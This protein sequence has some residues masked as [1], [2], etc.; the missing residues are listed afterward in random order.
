MNFIDNNFPGLMGYGLIGETGNSGL[1]G[2]SVYI[3]HLYGYKDK[4]KIKILLSKNLSINNLNENIFY[5]VDDIFIDN[6]GEVYK[7][8]KL[9][10]NPDDCEYIKLSD[11]YTESIFLNSN[12][13]NSFGYKRIYP[14]KINIDSYVSDDD[15]NINPKSN[16]YGTYINNYNK[17]FYNNLK[18]ES[19]SNIYSLSDEKDSIG[20]VLQKITD[21]KLNVQFGNNINDNIDLSIDFNRLL[22]PDTV[23]KYKDEDEYK[24]HDQ[25]YINNNV[26]KSFINTASSYRLIRSVGTKNY[27]FTYNPYDFFSDKSILDYI[28]MNITFYVDYNTQLYG[29]FPSKIELK[30]TWELNSNV[31][32]VNNVKFIHPIKMY[33]MEVKD[34]LTTMNLV[35]NRNERLSVFI[36]F[37]DKNT[38]LYVNTKTL[39]CL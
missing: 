13:I 2:L 27:K 12:Y 21:D 31:E 25:T 9:S 37:T 10:T 14:N 19:N 36:T 34:Y 24:V 29:G 32:N 1:S 11:I 3:T 15:I 26:L 16:I 20:L 17:L 35:F 28:T 23:Y 38:G 22:L 7:I 8:T 30:D 18:I 39:K 33:N 5:T 6:K 4:E